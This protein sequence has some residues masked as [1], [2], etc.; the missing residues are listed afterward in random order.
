MLPEISFSDRWSRG[1]KLWE[2]VCQENGA[3][4][5]RFSNQR[6]ESNLETELFKNFDNDVVTILK[7]KIQNER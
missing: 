1:R 6:T 5:K 4:Q 3:F 7:H 2:R